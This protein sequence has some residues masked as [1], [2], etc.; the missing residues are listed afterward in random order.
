MESALAV[1]QSAL[2]NRGGDNR[3]EKIPE[4]SNFPA[5]ESLEKSLTFTETRVYI[6]HGLR[7][8]CFAS[9]LIYGILYLTDTKLNIRSWIRS[10][11]HIPIPSNMGAT[12]CVL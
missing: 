2:L 8:I 10:P 12:T 5:P 1:L 4:Y 3:A 6:A 9:G 7:H 11:S